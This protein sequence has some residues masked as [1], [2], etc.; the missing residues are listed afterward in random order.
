MFYYSLELDIILR[1]ILL[2]RFSKD[3]FL[4]IRFL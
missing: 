4:N 2:C 1:I 3:F